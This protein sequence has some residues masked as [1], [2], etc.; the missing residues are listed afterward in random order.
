MNRHYYIS[1]DLDDLER[2]EQELESSGITTEQIHILSEREAEVE[3]H[4]HLHQVPSLLKQDFIHSG[5]RGLVIGVTLAVLALLMA[6]FSG[7][8]Q[9]A[10]GWI[11]FVFL[12]IVLLGFSIWEGTLVGLTNPNRNFRPFAERLRQGQHL[13]FVDV[14]ARQEPILARVVSHHPALEATGIGNAAP[15]WTVTLQQRLQRLRKMM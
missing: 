13:F 15:E 2:L 6:Y 4:Q 11:P 1:D 12:A 10:A 8:A 5:N 14:N 3:E 7:W 9:S